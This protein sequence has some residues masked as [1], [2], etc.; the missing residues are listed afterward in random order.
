MFRPRHPRLLVFWTALWLAGAICLA[1]VVMQHRREQAAEA[2]LRA[3]QAQRQID[4]ERAE[5]H[6]H[7]A[8]PRL[9][10]LWEECRTGNPADWT[11]P[12]LEARLND[13]KSFEASP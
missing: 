10:A 7:E 13:G 8:I 3:T 2:A 12:K 5:R 1:W 9:R 4:K 11:R 6:R